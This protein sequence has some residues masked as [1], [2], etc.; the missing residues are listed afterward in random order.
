MLRVINLALLLVLII[1]SFILV[2]KRYQSRLHYQT[3]SRLKVE[4]DG[5]NKEYSRLQIEEGT[6]SSNFVLQ[7]V[8]LHK[9]GLAEPDKNNLLEIK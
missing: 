3:L 8:A 5:L 6:Y 2:S 1:S 7:D 4:A 9:L